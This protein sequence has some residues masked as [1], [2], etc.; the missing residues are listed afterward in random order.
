MAKDNRYFALDIGSQQVSGAVFSKTDNGGLRL[1][2]FHRAN[3]VGSPYD[4]EV[5]GAQTKLAI[6]EVAK[7]LKMGKQDESNYIIS[8]Q[9]VLIK[10]ASLP[11]IDGERLEEIVEFEAQQQIPHQLEEVAW[12][13]QLVGE[14]GDVEMECVLAA[15][16]AD[17]LDE[18]DDLVNEAGLKTSGAEISPVTLYNALRFNYADIDS[19]IMM[20]DIG[21]RT[22]D[23]IFMEPDNMFIRTIALGGGEITKAIATEFGSEFG[24]ADL[25]KINDGFVALGGPY[26]DHEDPEIAGMSKMIRNS[27]TRLHSEIMRTINFYRSERGGSPPQLVLLSGGTSSLPFIRE[28]FAEKLNLPIDHFNAL[29]NVTVAPKVM[30]MGIAEHAHTLG[31]LVGQG[32]NEAGAVPVDLALVPESVRSERELQTRKPFLW[33]STFA[34]TALLLAMGFFFLRSTMLYDNKAMKLKD[35]AEMLT[36]SSKKIEDLKKKNIDLNAKQKPYVDSINQRNYWVETFNYLSSKM[37]SDTIWITGLTPLSNGEPI[38]EDGQEFASNV[39]GGDE[40]T[41]D[42]LLVKGLWRETDSNRRGKDVF[43]YLETLKQ[44]AV[45]KTKS[46][47]TPWFDLADKQISDLS[48]VDVGLPGNRYAYSWELRLPLPPENQVKYT[49]F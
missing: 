28:F 22:T 32:L 41:V 18:I 40:K 35:E 30:E 11:A 46:G 16:R 7:T 20:V 48:T 27:L 29:R 26:A 39:T 8:S 43:T 5:R 4:D 34:L 21:A 17:E 38:I 42:M 45:D 31:S 14:P 9:P 19:S 33:L 10:F 15:A 47:G 37:H 2:N 13:Y 6:K 36:D 44:D 24:A 12:G 49:K 1:D 25:K 23:L 3:L